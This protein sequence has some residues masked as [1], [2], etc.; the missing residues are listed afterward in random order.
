MRFRVQTAYLKR[1][2]RRT[3]GGA[4]HQEYWIP[5]KELAEFNRHIVGKIETI[6][7]FRGPRT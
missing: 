7:E 6:A 2:E 4:I 5:A 3:V 1:F